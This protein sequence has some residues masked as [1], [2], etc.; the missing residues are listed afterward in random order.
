MELKMKFDFTFKYDY[1][2]LEQYI[3]II[4]HLKLLSGRMCLWQR[5]QNI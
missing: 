5:L 3:F 2:N 4:L 1:V